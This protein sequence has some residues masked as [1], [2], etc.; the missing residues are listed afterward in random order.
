MSRPTALRCI[1]SCIG[2]AAAP[3]AGRDWWT[4]NE[5]TRTLAVLLLE[6]VLRDAVSAPAYQRL[7][8]A[9]ADL[10]LNGWSDHS[11]AVELGVTGKTIAKA[12][13]W[14]RA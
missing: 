11:I 10:R 13:R 1:R 4:R 2:S 9:A 7:A 3:D 14:L 12:I 6:Q 8:P 5:R